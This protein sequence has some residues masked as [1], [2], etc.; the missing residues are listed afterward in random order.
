M[1]EG[2]GRKK[3]TWNERIEKGEDEEEVEEQGAETVE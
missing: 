1:G 2:R 3:M